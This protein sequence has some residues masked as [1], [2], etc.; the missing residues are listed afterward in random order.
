MVNLQGHDFIGHV[1]L[2]SRH[3]R[4]PTS[5][6]CASIAKRS[7][8]ARVLYDPNGHLAVVYRVEDDGRILYIDAHPD[9][10]LT[11]GT[12]GRKF[13]RS[14]PG[15]GAGFKNW[16]PAK[17]VSAAKTADGTYLGG[18][19][20]FAKNAELPDYSTEQFFGNVARPAAIANGRP[21]PSCSKAKPS[22]TTTIC[23][24]N[25]RRFAGL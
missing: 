4:T 14:S 21:A 9:N 16:R 25:G 2:A 11:R 19:I 1:P 18:R 13:V 20:V 10:S 8:R 7:A 3:G 23:A 15:M 24:P 22:T 5:I 12:Y 6:P 17:L